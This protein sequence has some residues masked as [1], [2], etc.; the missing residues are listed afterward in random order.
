MK[1]LISISILSLIGL[2]SVSSWTISGDYVLS[3]DTTGAEGTFQGLE[4]EIIFD[5]NAPENSSM[6][7]LV[8]V[9]TI[10]TG[11]STKNRHAL[12]EKWFDV[13]NYPT[14][15]FVSS[16]VKKS[17]AGYLVTGE[18]TLH[19]VKKSVAIPFSFQEKAGAGVFEGAFEVDRKDYGIEGN[20]FGFAV[21]KSVEIKLRVPVRKS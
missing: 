12:N 10:D 20:F 4:G 11:N 7:V 13:A 14:I 18:L 6:N 16:S 1:T 21:G 2:W 8:D 15:S 9:K 17:T 3:F 5:P 19:G